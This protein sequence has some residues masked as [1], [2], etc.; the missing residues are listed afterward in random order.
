MHLNQ[1]LTNS[2]GKSAEHR[3]SGIHS[4]DSFSNC[5]GADALLSVES[6]TTGVNVDRSCCDI[7]LVAWSKHVICGWVVLD[8]TCFD[9]VVVIVRDQLEVVRKCEVVGDV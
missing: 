1:I 8:G 3:I 2:M 5:K 6:Q 4:N 9:K 7:V